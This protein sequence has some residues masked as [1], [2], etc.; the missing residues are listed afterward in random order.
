ML[1]RNAQGQTDAHQTDI[2]T[3]TL[4]DPAAS[5]PSPLPRPQ[6]HPS[7]SL[8]DSI[9]A[10]R[11]N[12]SAAAL[13][14]TPPPPDPRPRAR[15]KP[16]PSPLHS[17]TSS[18]SAAAAGGHPH[19]SH[20]PRSPQSAAAAAPYH[21]EPRSPR[22][23]LDAL[24]AEEQSSLSNAPAPTP[25]SN[26]NRNQASPPTPPN[27]PSSRAGTQPAKPSS[28][29]QLRNV[30]APILSSAGISPPLSPVTMPP[31]SRPGRPDTRPAAPP[32]NP[33]IDSAASSLS[34][35]A[36]QP[37]RGNP[38]H[39]HT[40]SQDVSNAQPPDMAALIATAGSPEAALMAMWRE[41]QSV[42]NHNNQLWRL[43]EKQ[44]SMVIGLQ[45]DLERAL[46]DKDRYRKK[47]KEYVNQV[48]PIPGM[49]PRS[50]TIESVVERDQSQSP[51]P[52]ERHDD[53]KASPVTKP[54]EHKASPLS[55]E[56]NAALLFPESQLANSPA[57]SSEAPTASNPTSSV[58][59]PTDYS[60]KP[61][62]LATKAQGLNA[63]VNESTPAIQE[64]VETG[65]EV[66][67]AASKGPA[68]SSPPPR[69]HLKTP[70]LSLTHATPEVGGNGFDSP[71]EKPAHPLRKPPP[72][73]LNLS[74]PAKPSAHLHPAAPGDRDES[75]YDDTLEVDEIPVVERGR[76]KTREEDDRVREAIAMQQEEVRSESKKKKSKSKSKAKTSE[77]AS[78][79]DQGDGTGAP[80]SPRQFSPL[81]AGLPLSPRHPP[82]NSLNALLSPTNS[83]SSMIAQRSVGSPPLMS[84]GLPNSPRPGDRPIGSPLPRNP[85]QEL[86]SPPMS[87]RSAVNG[88]SQ[89]ASR[90]PRQPVP[91]PPNTPQ[92]Y[93]SPQVGRP[94]PSTLAKQQTLST[95]LLKPPNAQPS[96]DSETGLQASGDLSNA[97]HVYRGLVSDQ[98]PGLLLPPNALP[99]I[100][101]KVFS[102]R[103]RPSRL[104]FLAPKPQEEDPVFILAIYARS[105]GKQLWRMEKTIVALPTLDAQLKAMCDFHGKL[106]DRAL[107][108]GHAPA[109][110]DAR[111]AALNQYFDAILETP[112]SEKAALIVCEFF[113]TDVIGAQNCDSLTP[114][115]SV[116][117]A[118]PVAKD[119]QRKEG[120]LTKRG[121]N[122]GGWKAR[123]FVLDGPEF[124]YYEIAGGAHL[125]TIKLHNAQIGKQS[126]QQSSSSPQRPDGSEENQYRHAF[127]I[128]EPKRKD[129]SSLVRHVLC[130]ESD[131]ER[132]AWVDA[133]LQ[134]VD[135][136]EQTS[137]VD[138]QASNS[139]RNGDHKKGHS[140]EQTRHKRKDSPE[141]DKRDRVQGLSYDDTVAAEAPI[142]GP[143]HREAREAKDPRDI[144]SHSPKNSSFSYD[145]THHPAISG[146]SNGAPIQNV[147]SW[148]NKPL[149]PP[150][151]TS[152]K[153][154][155]RSIFGFRGRGSNDL[156]IG[157]HHQAPE[158]VVM[159]NRNIFGIPLQEA[160]EFS[161]PVGVDYQLPAVVYRCL[162]YLKVKQAL[163]EEGIF[164]LSGSNIVIK[165]LRERFNTE[166]DVKLLDGQYYDVHAV[167]SLLKLYL[168]E[169]PASILTRE[170]HLDF[171]K[172][173]DM[174]ERKKKIQAFNVLVH[175]LP[176][177]NYELLRHV[178][179][180]LIE[181]VDNAA[182]NKMTVRNV[183]IVFAPTL[184]IPAPLISFFLTDYT[185]IFGPAIDE[186]SSPIHEI[187][188]TTPLGDEAVRSPR[189]Q[190]FS[191]IPTPAYN[192]TSFQQQQQHYDRP[193][194]SFPMAPA[195][196][197]YAPPQPPQQQQRQHAGYDTGFI[198]LR[199]SYES[200][201]Y[202]QPAYGDSYNSL[203]GALQ[204]PSA[205]DARQRRRESSM[206]MMNMGAGQRKG[207]GSL[208]RS[209]EEQR[210]NPM[211]V[212]EET[213]F[214]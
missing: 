186:A 179:S 10:L 68:P 88:I 197:Q 158:R 4:P 75:D 140:H 185:D 66:E 117:P 17:S 37:Y 167:A 132:D 202:E 84:P 153:D 15:R 142:R 162:E 100:E 198:P 79:A 45:K 182:M 176:R 21:D 147:E 154:K 18:S 141:M 139:N 157:G 209:R 67:N 50:D 8:A 33:S 160:V 137:P 118:S 39:S 121:K 78:E 150:V 194:S 109:K 27:L 149:A 96:P 11:E 25:N 178:S 187:V 94:E 113:S 31:P 53:A 145:S 16:I 62:S 69:G 48:P 193:P 127:L 23:K 211:M 103:L 126:Q 72:A 192:E 83:D 55:Q 195:A 52:S 95:D 174:D 184:N 111:R 61:L 116:A 161:Q 46:R 63:I 115:P 92:S 152:V 156:Q 105:D 177:V 201:A 73:P 199:P 20:T 102:S 12:T 19:H 77:G 119:R 131:E 76:R 51:A 168:R 40:S 104:S 64:A 81:Q 41:K 204:P 133:L 86:A 200:P 54:E 98:Y 29:A 47:L 5:T 214:D 166:G 43:V 91:L 151:Q 175:K 106:P 129:S 130:A 74:K 181:I 155:K 82:P 108:S 89:P 122:F 101:V 188:I 169:L 26:P 213:A 44:R 163:N 120:Y 85:R 172:V 205:R 1:Q 30:S 212:Q 210:R 183:G 36:S 71:R 170:L 189:H 143:T 203:N 138:A 171:L 146:P 80:S 135:Y 144:Y 3:S 60:V 24:I 42:T 65:A 207:S 38:N 34:S 99:S 93:T 159:Q 97:E 57:H 136:P 49:L 191:D 164:R 107:F 28:Y 148:G 58:N 87:P 165:A 110:M 14:S 124:R 13:P 125:G 114:E 59:S 206:L 196:P 6:L 112:M 190:M 9:R 56:S 208:P 180:F 134:H 128:L 32:R 2:T 35:S 123:Y 70:S 173:L 7:P 22:E 90:T